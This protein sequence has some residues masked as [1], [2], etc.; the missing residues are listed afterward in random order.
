MKLVD[1]ALS[2]TLMAPEIRENEREFCA[3]SLAC[4]KRGFPVAG[5]E[6]AEYVPSR[7][8]SPVLTN[9][10]NGLLVAYLV[11]QVDHFQYVQQRHLSD[12]GLTQDELH[13]RGVANLR[14]LLIQKD[15]RVQPYGNVFAVLCGGDFEASAVLVD[16]LWNNALAH[17]APNGFVAAIPCRDILAFCDAGNASGLQELRQIIERTQQGNHPIS[18][19]LYRRHAGMWEPYAD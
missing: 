18:S 6:E 9:L 3:R 7:Q 19:V 10:N 12:A 17:L 14:A 8:D 1:D 4:L 16:G 13:Q 11:D 2:S 5:A 15:I